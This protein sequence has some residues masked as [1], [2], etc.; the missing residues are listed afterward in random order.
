MNTEA[1]RELVWGQGHELYRDMPW[2]AEP[3]LYNVLVSEIMLQQTQVSRVLV[4]FDEFMHAFPTIE[5][6]AHASL[7]DILRA[8]SGLGYNRR[9]K[10]LHDALRLIDSQGAPQTLESLVKLPGIG[11]NTAAAIMNYV[12]E[13]PTAYIETNIRTVYFNYFFHSETQVTDKA[14]LTIVEETMDKEHPREW[15][16]ALMDFGSD[17][18]TKGLGRLDM[19]KHYVKQTPLKGSVREVR[20][21]ILQELGMADLMEEE[22]RV[23]VAADERFPSALSGLIADGLVTQTNTKLHLTNE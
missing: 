8:W 10:Y 18:K 4:K 22:L 23:R 3:T 14:L 2:R 12:Y 21:A 1:F 11:P 6:A 9:A 7:A 19:S 20:G 13:V 17:L 15:F 16:W 5:A